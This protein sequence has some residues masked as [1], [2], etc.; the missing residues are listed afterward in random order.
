MGVAI[1]NGIALR[2]TGRRAS[3]HKAYRH[4]PPDLCR[5][6]RRPTRPTRNDRA[7]R[8]P[9]ITAMTLRASSRDDVSVDPVR[10][11]IGAEAGG[12]QPYLLTGSSSRRIR[13]RPGG[14][15]CVLCRYD[16][17]PI[18]AEPPSPSGSQ[19][20]TRRPPRRDHTPSSSTTGLND[21]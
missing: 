21:L 11:Q 14:R 20:G 2:A 19:S 9:D 5:H 12:A 6:V 13:P 10:V 17:M 3:T 15:A 16:Q 7:D 4:R 1:I 18:T 8:D